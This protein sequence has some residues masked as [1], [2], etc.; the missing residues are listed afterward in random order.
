[1]QFALIMAVLAALAMAQSAPS[2]PVSGGTQRLV[3]ACGGIS[4]VVLL[5]HQADLFG[6]RLLAAGG[7]QASW[8]QSPVQTFAAA[9]E[10]LAAAGAG[11]NARSWQH[12][13]IA[14]RVDFLNRLSRDPSRE[15][16]FHQWVRFLG[17]LLIGIVV[18]P[19]V[20]Q[21]LLG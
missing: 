21:V 16:H 20:C 11:R 2:Q 18:G 1:M 6:W 10:K 5:E 14:R 13:S 8:P 19:L 9:L 7:R 12:A 3:I 15:L 4:L 17:I